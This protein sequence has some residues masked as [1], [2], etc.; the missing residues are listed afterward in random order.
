[1]K[2]MSLKITNNEAWILRKKG[3]TSYIIVDNLEKVEKE[4]HKITNTENIELLKLSLSHNGGRLEQNDKFWM[5]IFL[6][7]KKNKLKN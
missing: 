6:I 3:S 1:M 5:K 2:K 7:M 4:L